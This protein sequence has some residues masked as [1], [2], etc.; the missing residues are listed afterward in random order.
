MTVVA[1][2]T[3]AEIPT[4]FAA[5]DDTLFGILTLPPD[6]SAETVVVL[7]PGGWYSTSADR[8]RSFVRIARELAADGLATFRFDY[9]GIGE[10]TGSQGRFRLDDPNDEDL[11][12]ALDWLR[13]RGMRRAV[14][15]GVCFGARTALLVAHQRPEVEGI[16]LISMPVS[17]GLTPIATALAQRLSFGELA[18][19]GL[20]LSLLRQL[21]DPA[22]RRVL[23]KGLR[24]VVSASRG[25][26]GGKSANGAPLP[27]PGLSPVVGNLLREARERVPILMIY[28]SGEE[29]HVD[30]EHARASDQ[31]DVLTPAPGIMDLV[32]CSV[33][34]HGFA[35]IQ[36]QD[37]VATALREW[38]AP[39]RSVAGSTTR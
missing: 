22:M 4:F 14:L 21:R 9:H 32:V 12:G 20:R 27:A 26:G 31:S 17:E 8:A 37:E 24:A 25:S 39:W 7:V 11:R 35:R 1:Q 38:C 18:R 33:P 5:G 13:A 36:V 34:A 15:V 28:G 29:E 30:F 3:Y 6:G 16:V 10:S 19:R 2:S 23:R